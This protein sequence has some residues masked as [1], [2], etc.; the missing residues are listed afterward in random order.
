[1]YVYAYRH[2]NLELNKKEQLACKAKILEY[3]IMVFWGIVSVILANTLPINYMAI[4]GMI[5]FFIGP[6]M[7]FAM[8]YYYAKRLKKLDNEIN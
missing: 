1:M 6:S 8:Y 3:G 7:F 4:S 2:K 5:Y